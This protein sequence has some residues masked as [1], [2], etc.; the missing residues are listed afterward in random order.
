MSVLSGKVALVTGGA[1]GIGA[2]TAQRLSAEGAAVALTYV[3]SAA[4]AEALVGAIEADG[5]QALAIQADSAHP[6]EVRAAIAATVDRFGGLDI[7]VNNA[8]IQ[9]PGTIWDY[10]LDDLDAMIAVN[11]KGLFVATQEALRHMGQ[12]GRI[13]N[14]GS[15]SS[16]HMPLGGHAVYAMT[17]GAVAS[18]T[19]GLARDLGPRGITINNV[20]PGRIDTDM[21]R[22][23]IGPIA[24]RMRE[25]IALQRFGT[26]DEVAALV[27]YLAGPEAAFVTGASLKV[28]GGT[29]L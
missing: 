29:S 16:D 9:R 5:G 27:A 26:T 23:A 10:A 4:P 14:I 15:I 22:A 20:Q 1:R 21:I 28:D 18:L 7:L 17:K 24:D 6:A 12:G 3:Q 19:R 11:I 13:I 25:A 8:G 2:A